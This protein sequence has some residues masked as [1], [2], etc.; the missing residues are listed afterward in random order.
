MYTGRGHGLLRTGWRGV[1]MYMGMGP[2]HLRR[3]YL[4]VGERTI[5]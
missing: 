5:F 3:G 1:F 4:A 2:G